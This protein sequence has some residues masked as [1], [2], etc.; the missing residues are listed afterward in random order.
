MNTGQ[1]PI[2]DQ[3]QTP[4]SVDHIPSALCSVGRPP[5]IMTGALLWALRRHFATANYIVDAGLR[6]YTWHSDTTQTKIMIEPYTSWT[7]AAIQALQMRPACLVRRGPWQSQKLGFAD[8]YQGAGNNRVDATVLISDTGGVDNGIKH[9]V[10]IQGQHTVACMAGKGAEAEALGT[11]VFYELLEF[12]QVIRED[13][14]LSVF[15]VSGLG[16]TAKVEDSR[17]H[18]MAPV[19]LEYSFNHAWS[20]QQDGLPVKT[21]AINVGA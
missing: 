20:V 1:P 18:W 3:L 16:P 4:Q 8:Q 11:E 10:I 9:E 2:T 7:P 15:K 12:Q 6:A 19:Q 21:A 14:G 17:E 13:L 5:I